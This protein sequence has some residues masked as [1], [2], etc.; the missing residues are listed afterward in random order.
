MPTWNPSHPTPQRPFALVPSGAGPSCGKSGGSHR[1]VGLWGHRP[2]VHMACRWGP[3]TTTRHFLGRSR[4]GA[5]MSLLPQ[6]PAQAS[7]M[8]LGL[9]DSLGIVPAPG[10][11]QAPS[12][13]PSA[14]CPRAEAGLRP[15]PVLKEPSW[16]GGSGDNGPLMPDT[17]E[18]GQS[19]P[20][21]SM[22]TSHS[23]LFHALHRT[24][25]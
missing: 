7:C 1:A 3:Q 24:W 14:N 20:R 5:V 21:T 23:G 22:N 9:P 15:G 4:D 13:M 10:T 18:A 8:S 17:T 25:G 12:L 11:L 16:R 6:A 19:P 2:T